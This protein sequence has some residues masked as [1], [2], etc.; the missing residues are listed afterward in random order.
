MT[1]LQFVFNYLL[2]FCRFQSSPLNL[3]TASTESEKTAGSIIL[4]KDYN[5]VEALIA[6]ESLHGF[7]GRSRLL[8][9]KEPFAAGV[10]HSE[11]CR[12]IL[13][14]TRATEMQVF[15]FCTY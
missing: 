12:Q 8:D 11:K 13:A 7:M 5:P 2:L 14:N 3:T 9:K 4:P 1:I 15:N 10:K 6:V